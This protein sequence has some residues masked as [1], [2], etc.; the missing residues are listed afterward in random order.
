MLLNEEKT[1]PLKILPSPKSYLKII[2][3]VHA[4]EEQLT[5]KDGGLY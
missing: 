5:E 1:L 3:L 2:L 4:F